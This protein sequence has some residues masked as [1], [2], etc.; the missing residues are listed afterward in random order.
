MLFLILIIG[1][2]VSLS[3]L[4]RYKWVAVGLA[5]FWSLELMFR[6]FGIYGFPMVSSFFSKVI[7]LI[8]TIFLCISGEKMLYL[9]GDDE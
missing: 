4:K 2:L 9:I 6:D 1:V 7:F 5:L 3:L 8:A